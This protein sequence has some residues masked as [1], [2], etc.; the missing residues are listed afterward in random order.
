MGTSDDVERIAVPLLRAAGLDLVDVELRSGNIVVTVD[1]EG[2]I[3]LDTLASTSK[4]ISA[5][6]D[7]EG[8]GP[9]SRYELEVS[10]PGL[11]R[12]LR[13][14]EHFRRFVG[15]Q[16]SLRTLPGVD[17]ERR[18]EGELVSADEQGVVVTAPGSTDGHRRFAYGDIE[19]AHTIFDWKA[20][21][22]GSPSP[23][24]RSDRRREAKSSAAN[25]E[26]ENAS[27]EM[28]DKL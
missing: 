1:R 9:S 21:L 10:S 22:A 6:I 12:R 25:G 16:I 18:I 13:R 5:A 8:V 17:G 28:A 14:P 11:E 3:D 24:A 23:T 27:G 15:H 19:R 26:R 7:R 2:G 4:A 20:A